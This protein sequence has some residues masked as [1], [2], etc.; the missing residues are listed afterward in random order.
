[1]G[2]GVSCVEVREEED[3]RVTVSARYDPERDG[4]GETCPDCGTPVDAPHHSGCE[5]FRMVPADG[6]PAAPGVSSRDDL[7]ALVQKIQ[8]AGKASEATVDAWVTQFKQSVPH[9]YASDLIFWPDQE[10]LPE[11]PT[12]EQIVDAALNYKP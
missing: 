3:G 2:A 11:N 12:A 4:P 9:P 10:G 7:I 1:M 5:Y 6:Q 8:N